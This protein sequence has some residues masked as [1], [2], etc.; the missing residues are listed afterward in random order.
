MGHTHGTNLLATSGEGK[1]SK[2]TFQGRPSKNGFVL[3]LLFSHSLWVKSNGGLVGCRRPLPQLIHEASGLWSQKDPPLPLSLSPSLSVAGTRW[4]RTHQT[5]FTRVLACAVR[6]S[7][8][9]STWT[10]THTG[11]LFT[12]QFVVGVPVPT[13]QSSHPRATWRVLH[14]TTCGCEEE[15]REYWMEPRRPLR[16]SALPRA[17][18]AQ[19]ALLWPFN[20]AFLFLHACWWP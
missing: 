11:A 10:L 18:S 5:A 14:T 20:K 19:A 13:Y 12:N 4:C 8:M 17:L 1:R 3:S 2:T 9:L 16:T 6:L 7:T 15:R